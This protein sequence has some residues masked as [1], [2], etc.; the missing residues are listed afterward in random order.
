MSVGEEVRSS[1][2]SSIQ[3]AWGRPCFS[4]R[5]FISSDR[6][7]REEEGREKWK[8]KGGWR[9]KGRLKEEIHYSLVCCHCREGR[10]GGRGKD[11][12]H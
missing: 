7:R 8:K 10:R 4:A 2:S 1:S 3:V 11:K 9:E 12:T 6:G 5:A